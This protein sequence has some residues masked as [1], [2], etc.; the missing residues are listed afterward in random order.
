MK[1]RTRGISCTAGTRSSGVSFMLSAIFTTLV[2]CGATQDTSDGAVR[3]EPEEPQSTPSA[4]T[5]H[6]YSGLDAHDGTIVFYQGTYYLYG[7]RYGCGFHW[8]V[9]NTPFCGFGVWTSTDLSNWSYRGLLFNPNDHNY[10]DNETWNA[11]CGAGGEGCFNPRMIQRPDG[12]WILWFNAPRDFA[13][14]GNNAY[15][16]MGC[17]SPLGPCGENAGAPYGSTH[18]PSPMNFCYGN[19]DFTIVTNGANAYIYCT[20]ADQT[21]S[22]E[23]L[24]QWW[25]NGSSAGAGKLAGLGNVE[26]P[27]VFQAADGTWIMTYS[28]PNCGYCSGDGTGY[29]TAASPLG[30]WSAPG[31]TGFSAP[32]TGRRDIS[33]N[34]C[35]GQPRTIFTIQGQPYQWIDLWGSWSG[36]SRNQTNAGIHLEPIVAAAPYDKPSDGALF[37]GGIQPFTCR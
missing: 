14:R 7:T 28:D 34:S 9:A 13:Q 31:N 32:P 12:V 2:A 11:T 23:Q 19:G 16:A 27:G 10:W 26:A 36:D 8:Q 30:L 37:A 18:K 1:S 29:A 21:L 20:L 25:T 22:V 4:V 33:A 24:D 15:Y 3:S 6:T 35:G 5:T 17:N